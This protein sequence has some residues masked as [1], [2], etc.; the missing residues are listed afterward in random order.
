MR[1]IRIGSGVGYSGDR[2][3]PSVELAE[4]GGIQS[5][6]C[7]EAPSTWLLASLRDAA[8]PGRRAG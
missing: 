2:I 5:A 6:C 3:E 1:T 8:A 4:R 7:M